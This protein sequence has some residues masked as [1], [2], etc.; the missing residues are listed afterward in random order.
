MKLFNFISRIQELN[1]CSREFSFNTPGQET[2]PVPA[3]EM[4]D[5]IDHSMPTIGNIR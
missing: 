5:I 3:G 1:S 2:A 4:M